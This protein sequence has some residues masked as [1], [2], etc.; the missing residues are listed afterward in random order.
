MR[1]LITGASGFIGGHLAR[2]IVDAGHQVVACLRDTEAIQC[3]HPSINICKADFT[4]DQNTADWTP[5]LQGVDVVINTVGIIRELGRQ[6]FD[7]LHTRTPVALFTACETAGV[8]R[9]IQISALGA[10][11]TAFSQYHLS[12]KAADDRLM[13]LNLDW[14]IVMP[15]IV[16]GPGAKSMAFFKALAALPLVPLVEQGDQQVQP[17][18]ISDLCR[19]VLQLLEPDAPRQ[20]RIEMVGPKALT[21]KEIYSQLRVW[22]GIGG[23][24]RYISTPYTASLLA[25]KWGGFLGNTP[26]TTEAIEML[27]RGNTGDVTPFVEQ[28]GFTPIGF[29]AALAAT[30]AQQPDRWHAGL[31]FLRPALR[32]SIAFVWL[33]TGITSAFIY[34]EASSFALLAKTGVSGAWAPF[35]L[36]GAAAID[37]ALGIATAIS[38]RTRQIGGVQILIILLYTLIISSSQPGQWLHPFGPISKN[39]PLLISIMIMIVL[40][41]K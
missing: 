23:A 7:T 20:S 38:Y 17:I 16:Y 33:F 34:P 25:A 5:R 14:A 9:V 27:R 2:A 40:E 39:M 10:D 13:R 32:L 15:S 6:T 30:P 12:K 35:M 18:H 4:L 3:H 8:K 36:Y 19:A 24:P 29:D 31:Y 41:K 28:F 26:M 21:L 1:I 37:L 11:K 22:L